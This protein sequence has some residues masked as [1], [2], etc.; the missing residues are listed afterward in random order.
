MRVLKVVILFF[1]FIA[2]INAQIETEV[3]N[4]S[5]KKHLYEAY[6]FTNRPVIYEKDSSV[7]FQNKS[8]DQTNSLHFCYY[9][10]VNDSIIVN[11]KAKNTSDKYP[12][13]AVEHN[14]F[15]DIYE[16]QRL[17]LGIK[18]F[19]FIVG[20]YGKTFDKQVHSYMKRFKEYYG[21]SLLKGAAL[22]TFA[23]GTENDAY[24]YYNAVRKS[25]NG[26][27]DFAIFQHMLDEFMSDS[28][29]FETHPNDLT[30]DILFSSMGNDLF[31]NYLEER[32]KQ[33][34]ELVKT[35][36]RIIFQGSVAPRNSLK[37]N[38]AFGELY[39]MTDTLDVYVNNRDA[40][41]ALSSLLE[42]RGRL[43]NHG[44]VSVNKLPDYIN[45]IHLEHL[46]SI[47]DIAGL[48]HDYILTN[49]VMRNEILVDIDNS[50]DKKRNKINEVGIKQN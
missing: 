38:K 44:P 23:W 15:Y 1:I 35:Y 31:K 4:P 42:F 16:Y 6:F 13:G 27:A 8:T 33:N 30:I 7:H 11:Y 12:T 25:K 45:V 21:D 20:G 39:K 34:I 46:L 28:V 10:F 9:D 32:K 41:L 43:G 2:N 49:P 14:F 3:V 50:L 40:L 19:Y 5:I 17:E 29:Y 26:A 37:K 24:Q 36:N 47:S 22:V 48:G 18:N